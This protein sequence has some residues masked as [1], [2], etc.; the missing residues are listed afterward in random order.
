MNKQAAETIE[1]N[2]KEGFR[3][4]KL[5]EGKLAEHLNNYATGMIVLYQEKPDTLGGHMLLYADGQVGW[6]HAEALK[7]ALDLNKEGKP[8][9]AED[10]WRGGGEKPERDASTPSRPAQPKG[11]DNPWLPPKD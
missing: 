10:A 8:V 1:K 3:S 7:Q 11:E 2:E 6:L 5:A 9:P 4:F